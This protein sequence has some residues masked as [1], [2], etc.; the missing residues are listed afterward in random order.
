MRGSNS[1]GDASL[2]SI[3]AIS[4]PSGGR[5]FLAGR[6]SRI[7]SATKVRG[8]DSPRWANAFRRTSRGRVSGSSP[9]VTVKGSPCRATAAASS[10]SRRANAER[11]CKASTPLNAESRYRP[12]RRRTTPNRS[13]PTKRLPSCATSAAVSFEVRP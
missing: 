1:S 8:P 7:G 6:A 3:S 12:R 13:Q 10:D 11:G 4:T 9:P 2:S 5:G